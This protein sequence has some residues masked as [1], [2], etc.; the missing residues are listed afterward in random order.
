V[1]DGALDDATRRVL[2]MKFAAGLFDQPYSD[3]TADWHIQ[4]AEKKALARQAAQEGT[5]LISNGVKSA[6]STT[7]KKPWHWTGSAAPLP[8]DA[9]KIKDG[10]LKVGV[11]G[12]LAYGAAVDSGYI[13]SY[14][15]D[16]AA[17]SLLD[18]L[19]YVTREDLLTYVLPSLHPSFLPNLTTSALSSSEMDQPLPQWVV[20]ISCP[21]L[22]VPSW[23]LLNQ[24]LR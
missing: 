9:K 17:I 16:T 10:S 5:V 3:E 2:T 11:I 23:T 13:G 21:S 6:A 8:L 20:R 22:W 12:P 1:E 4:S 7:L 24:T 14:A 15:D 19:K 18:G